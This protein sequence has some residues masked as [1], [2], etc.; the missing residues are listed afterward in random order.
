VKKK[1]NTHCTVG[2]GADQHPTGHTAKVMYFLDFFFFFVGKVRKEKRKIVI[3]I[4]I[5]INIIHSHTVR[6]ST[7]GSAKGGGEVVFDVK[8]GG[9]G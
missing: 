9:Q 6:G 3:V 7:V 4:I 2:V 1:K 5:I 8:V